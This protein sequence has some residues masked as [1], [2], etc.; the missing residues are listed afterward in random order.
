MQCALQNK[1][2]F[3]E[4][5]KLFL[6]FMKTRYNLVSK[7]KTFMTWHSLPKMFTKRWSGY[8]GFIKQWIPIPIFMVGNI[9]CFVWSFHKVPAQT[10]FSFTRRHW[11]LCKNHTETELRYDAKYFNPSRII[12]L[13]TLITRTVYINIY[14][15]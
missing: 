14:L 4:K 3:D 12:Y 1:Y 11:S 13:S 8:P 15:Q 9:H 5:I 7:K 6:C 2:N 10:F